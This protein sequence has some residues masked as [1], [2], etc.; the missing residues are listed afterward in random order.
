LVA[1]NFIIDQRPDVVVGIPDSSDIERQLYLPVQL[2]ELGVSL[3]LAF[4]MSD[5]AKARG[6]EFDME[7]LSRL[8]RPLSCRR[9]GTK[10]S[11]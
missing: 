6:Y 7:K 1:R 9:S 2:M 11:G 10:G 4:N 5:M 3:V 8:L